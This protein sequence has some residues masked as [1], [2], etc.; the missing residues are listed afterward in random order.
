M[1]IMIK[2][3]FALAFF[4]GANFFIANRLLRGS[5]AIWP[6]ASGWIFAA[7]FVFLWLLTIMG[8]APHSF[9][10]KWYMNRVGAYWFGVFVCFVCLFAAAEVLIL[11]PAVAQVVALSLLPDVRL[12]LALGVAAVTVLLV[13]WGRLRAARIKVVPYDIQIKNNAASQPLKIAMIA[14]LHL[15]ASDCEAHLPAIVKFINKAQP[16]IV[17]LVGDVF[18]DDINL[19]RNPAAVMASLKRIQAKYGVFACLG[20][21]D[22]GLTFHEMVRF[23]ADSNV[24]L[25]NDEYVVIDGRYVLI[26]RVDAR[27]VFGFDG[28]ARRDTD[29]VLEAA[30]ATYP[31]LPIIVMDH[32]PANLAQYKN[33]VRL[34]L[35]GHTHAGQSFPF[36]WLS[37]VVHLV[38]H[39]HFQQHA[40]APH[41]VVTSG[42][43]TWGPPLRLG[44]QS[45]VVLINLR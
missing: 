6:Q 11:L 38:S 14:D 27:P 43:G 22:G 29:A 26:G 18:N 10:G 24:R 31:T 45:E 42:V 19:I 4:V 39:G 17:C 41:L 8:Y 13:I 32:N 5:Q 16:D 23:L 1:K 30:E 2:I 9:G 7:L 36:N 20:N 25:L 21:H 15:G 44:T 40:D 28:L 35:S 37:K 12:W 3:L 33:R 34:M